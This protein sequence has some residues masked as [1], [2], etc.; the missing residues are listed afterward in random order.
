MNSENTRKVETMLST[1]SPLNSPKIKI[2]H[3][4][5]E[6]YNRSKNLGK[7]SPIKSIETVDRDMTVLPKENPLT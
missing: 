6:E 5:R 4:T 2:K 1:Q 3:M 7:T